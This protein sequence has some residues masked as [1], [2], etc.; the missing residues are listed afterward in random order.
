MRMTALQMGRFLGS[1]Q[2]PLSLAMDE[3]A[4]HRFISFLAEKKNELERNPHQHIKI[5]LSHD[6]INGVRRSFRQRILNGERHLHTLAHLLA[7]YVF[8]GEF[9]L[10]SNVIGTLPVSDRPFLIRERITRETLFSQSDLD[11]GNHLLDN[12]RYQK[13]RAWLPLELSAN[14]VEYIPQGISTRFGVN[15]L[16][17]RVKAEEELWNKV[18]DELFEVDKLLSRDKH[19]MQFSK[20]VKDIFG[21]KVV[22]EDEK[23]CLKMHE[24]L[25]NLRADEP[26]CRQWLNNADTV[27]LHP[28]SSSGLILDFVETKNYLTCSPAEMKKTGWKALKSVVNWNEHMFELQFQPLSNYYMELD[29]MAGPSH[30]SFKTRRDRMREELTIQYPLYGFYRNLLKM[31]FLGG[32][33]SFDCENASVVIV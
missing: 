13:D 27:E 14:F 16:T 6:L 23:T 12:F 25:K 28:D 9:E 5:E 20:Y 4:L 18:T 22:C 2:S 29:H 24:Q 32:D 26:A 17:S 7:S 30:S 21:I 19:F 1:V 15:R 8:A 10:H 3:P 31:L 33:S 11:L